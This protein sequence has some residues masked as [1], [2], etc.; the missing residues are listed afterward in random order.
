MTKVEVFYTGSPPRVTA[1]RCRGHSNGIRSGDVDMV[2][3]SVSLCMEMLEEGLRHVVAPEAI[4]DLLITET[5]AAGDKSISWK[6]GGGYGVDLLAATV[7]NT[8]KNIAA[9][10]PQNVSIEVKEDKHEKKVE[11]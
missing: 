4:S 1:V 8:L 10:Y 2:C 9:M 3:A 7:A 5:R 6:K 11:S